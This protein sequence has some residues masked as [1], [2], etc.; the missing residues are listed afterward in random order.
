MRLRRLDARKSQGPPTKWG[1]Q[2]L[3]F[4]FFFVQRRSLFLFLLAFVVGI[5]P[6]FRGQPGYFASHLSFSW[7]DPT[8]PAQR[9]TNYVNFSKPPRPRALLIYTTCQNTVPFSVWRTDIPA[10]GIECNNETNFWDC[11]EAVPYL[12]FLIDNYD[13]PLA[14]KYIFAHG[15]DTSWHYQGN[16]FDA[17]DNLLSATY[18]RK[19]SY[20]GVFRGNYFTGA[21]GDGEEYWAKPLY[22]Y[23]FT[24]TSLPPEPIEDHNQR[25]CCATFWLNSE[26]VWSRKKEE[27][28]LM[29]DRLRNW[30]HEH[31]TINPNPAWFCGRTMEYTWHII[32]T[33]KAFIDACYL[34][35]GA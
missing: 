2:L 1:S 33:K 15:H 19:L 18:F 5:T 29:R 13:T 12:N 26:L 9:Y 7:Q 8:N 4:R 28:I 16:F 11:N 20:G 21:W 10:I 34:C 3:L 22:Q 27:Y 14:D 17:L 6:L 30:S 35:Q 31:Q 25:P 32:F 23:L 24:G